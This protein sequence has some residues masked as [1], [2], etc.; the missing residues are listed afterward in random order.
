MA[1]ANFALEAAQRRVVALETE[2]LTPDL[3][4]RRK[5]SAER[6]L[7]NALNLLARIQQQEQKRKQRKKSVH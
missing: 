4:V 6:A 2:L 1:E 3:S 7:A 5:N